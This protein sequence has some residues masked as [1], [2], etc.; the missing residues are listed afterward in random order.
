MI[1]SFAE[2]QMGE[3][4]TVEGF[5]RVPENPSERAIKATWASRIIILHETDGK[6]YFHALERMAM[7]TESSVEFYGASV[8]RRLLGAVHKRTLS[9][10]MLRESWVNL[11]FRLRQF[12]IDDG[13][14]IACFAPYDLRLLY[15]LPL[16]LRR[17]L[18]VI[19][20]TS[21]PYWWKERVPRPN[22]V[23]RK[24]SESLYCRWLSRCVDRIVVVLAEGKRQM[25]TR[26]ELDKKCV[27]I[28]HTNR[29][30][31]T[32]R[33]PRT[34]PLKVLYVGKFLPEKGIAEYLEAAKKLH[35]ADI[36]FTM[37]GYG[38]M[39]PAVALAAQSGF[40]DYQ[41]QVSDSKVLSTIYSRHDILI[42]PSIATSRWEEL[43][44]IV[45]IEAMAHGVVPIATSHVGPRNIITDGVDGLLM[46][47][48][49]ASEIEA[50]ILRLQKDR[51]ILLQMRRNAEETAKTYAIETVTEKWR[52]LIEE[53]VHLR[54]DQSA[55]S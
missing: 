11:L 53:L 44:G 21:W 45:I 46:K 22:S 7:E 25:A 55:C 23:F 10:Q 13:V 30:T 34:E 31:P 2:T 27:I 41:H 51:E 1:S 52:V 14:V 43:F 28:P 37:V 8:L 42:V 48:G 15:F 26:A 38:T 33:A 49:T 36:S 20:H 50:S 16:W 40:V 17:R 18:I 24:L 29:L 9:A 35:S 19:E 47:A 39:Q 32:A 6:P 5:A 3:G 12:A 4:H 54:H